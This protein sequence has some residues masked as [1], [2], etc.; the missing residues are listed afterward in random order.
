MDVWRGEWWQSVE[1]KN[2][3]RLTIIPQIVNIIME[4]KTIKTN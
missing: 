4:N 3:R 1:E 2:Q